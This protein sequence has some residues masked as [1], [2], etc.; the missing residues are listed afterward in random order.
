MKYERTAEIQIAMVACSDK[1][2]HLQPT[3]DAIDEMKK[4]LAAVG[5]INPIAVHHVTNKTYRLFAGATRFR[6]ACELG[7]THIRASV[8]SGS[9]SDYELYE[10]ME[11]VDRREL[12]REKRK[13]MKQ[14]I[15]EL[16]REQMAAVKSAKGGRGKKGGVS[17]AARDAGMTRRT[18]QRRQKPA[19]NPESAQVSEPTTEARQNPESGAVSEPS[20]K[21]RKSSGPDTKFSV[22]YPIHLYDQIETLAKSQ[23]TTKA[24]VVRQLVHEWFTLSAQLKRLE[25]WATNQRLSPLQ[26]LQQLLDEKLGKHN[27]V[28]GGATAVAP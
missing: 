15:R 5:Q 21:Q 7:W 13:E 22:Q 8:F 16:Q 3:R 23:N 24:A 11:N 14:R 12:S 2:R 1:G 27:P 4:S 6:A 28:N 20:T 25:R 26:G 9:P 10:L 19:Q 17:Q 18:A